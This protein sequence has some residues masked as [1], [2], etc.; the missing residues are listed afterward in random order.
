MAAESRTDRECRRQAVAGCRCSSGSPSP[1]SARV[2][3]RPAEQD[4]ELCTMADFSQRVPLDELRG[5]G[6][7]KGLQPEVL[8]KIPRWHTINGVHGCL[9]RV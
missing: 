5:R 3:A 4:S 6:L 1:G 8:E 2:A 7:M 9:L